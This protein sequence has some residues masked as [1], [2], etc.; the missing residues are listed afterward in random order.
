M[1]KPPTSR[2][3][4][5]KTSWLHPRWPT[6]STRCISKIKMKRGRNSKRKLATGPTLSAAMTC[7]PPSASSS[8]T[9]PNTRWCAM[10]SR[11]GTGRSEERRVGKERRGRWRGDAA[12]TYQ[13]STTWLTRGS[14]SFV[15]SSRRRHTRWPR[16]WSSDVCSS[17]LKDEAWEKFQA[18]ASDWADIVSRDDM[19]PS[20]R[21]KLVDPTE[22]EVVRD[23]F[24]GRD[25]VEEVRDQSQVIDPLVK[26]LNGA[27][28][29]AAGLA[30]IMLIA[31]V[32]LITTTIRLS[33]MRS[34]E[35]SCRER[36]S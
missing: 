33:A 5:L 17:D 12:E 4:P 3:P 13:N 28:L 30:G 9:R 27:T 15:V 34:E 21:I 18:Q 35:R 7:R 20:F 36:S 32:L 22:Y 29:L 26:L 11:A 10:P 8:S 16:D 23:A 25:G 2:S 24:S 6:T 14:V 1:V 19:Q 31:A